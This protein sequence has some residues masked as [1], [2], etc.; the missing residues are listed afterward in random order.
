MA[1]EKKEEKKEQTIDAAEFAALQTSVEKLTQKNRELIQAEKDERKKAETAAA[2]AAKKSGDVDALEKSWQDKLTSETAARDDT[3][4]EY[5]AM[6]K[7]MTVGTEAQKLASELALPGSA[8]ALL[9]HIERRL[10]VD[11]KEGHPI[12][13]VLGSDGKP[14]A[15]SLADLKT[16][17]GENKAFAP[18]LIGS[19][20]SG[21]GDVG[22][23]GDGGK[24]K[25]I[26]RTQFDAMGA[27]ERMAFFKDSGKVVDAA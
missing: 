26:T 10:S 12:V 25:T 24:G 14:S 16:E 23:K 13:R 11:V 1:E 20:A 4:S 15:L 3:I 9:P 5:Q 22:K 8:E 18:L 2:E 7:R 27:V 19:K 21:S 6:V 17:I